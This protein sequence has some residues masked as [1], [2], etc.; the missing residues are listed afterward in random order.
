MDVARRALIIRRFI[1]SQGRELLP[2]AALFWIS[3]VRD[4]GWIRLPGDADPR[5]G[6]RWF[7]AGLIPVFAFA[8]WSRRDYAKRYGGAAQRSED[9]ATG[10]IVTVFLFFLLAFWIQDEMRLPF[11]FPIL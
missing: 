4:L 1:Q 6:P 10:P 8:A 3:C 2:L 7:M 5:N 11:S 9:S